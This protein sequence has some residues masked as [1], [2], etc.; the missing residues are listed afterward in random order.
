MRCVRDWVADAGSARAWP[1]RQGRVD[2]SVLDVRR[3]HRHT[4]WYPQT[5]FG[6]GSSGL[7]GIRGVI[8]RRRDAPRTRVPDQCLTRALSGQGTIEYR[9]GPIIIAVGAQFS[10]R[11]TLGHFKAK[12]TIRELKFG[13]DSAEVDGRLCRPIALTRIFRRRPRKPSKRL[14]F[15]P[16]SK[17]AETPRSRRR[18]SGPNTNV[19]PAAPARPR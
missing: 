16:E 18:L 2:R 1:V 4:A 12:A 10:G 19:R 9:V 3:R 6:G 15:R 8:R 11:N 13:I 17:L 14:A 5:T 7:D